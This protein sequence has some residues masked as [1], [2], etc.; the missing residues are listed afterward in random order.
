MNITKKP[1]LRSLNG[2]L[3]LYDLGLLEKHEKR[4]IIL[5][6]KLE[7]YYLKTKILFYMQV[8][9]RSVKESLIFIVKQRN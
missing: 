8:N 9:H 4:T 3:K 2:Y 1:S 7:L 6:E 5:T